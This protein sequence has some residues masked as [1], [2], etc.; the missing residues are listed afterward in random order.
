MRLCSRIYKKHSDKHTTVL[1]YSVSL[2]TVYI[3]QKKN[4]SRKPPA[5]EV[6][7][8]EIKEGGYLLSRI[9]LQYHRRGR[10]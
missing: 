7:G 2:C 1:I 4:P 9:A 5:V 10:A 3:P 8:T 6:S